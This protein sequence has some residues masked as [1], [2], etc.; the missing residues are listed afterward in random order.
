MQ[1][2][3]LPISSLV[4]YARNA[5]THSDAQVAQIAGSIR[6]FG[7]TNP[8]LIDASGGIIAGHGRVMAARALGMAD[9]P[10]IRLSHLTDVQRRA[11]VLADNRIAMNSGWDLDM[12]ALEFT[13]LQ[14]DGVEIPALG[15]DDAEIATILADPLPVDIDDLPA[16]L[17]HSVS[18]VGDVWIMGNHRLVCGDSM[19]DSVVSAALGGDSA[20]LTILDPPY[21][22][23]D[24]VWDAWI[25]DPCIVF[26]QARHLRRVPDALWRF[27][28]VIVKRYRHRSATVQI[29]HRHAFVAQCGTVKRLPCTTET[30]PSVIEQEIDRE[31]DHA[32]PVSLLVEHMTKWT[33]EWRRCID[34]FAGSCSSIIAAESCGRAC[35]AIELDPVYVDIGV[36]RWQELTGHDAILESSGR[37]FADTEAERTP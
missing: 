31:H 18:R 21:E 10:C 14:I 4:P 11:Y 22:M 13:E 28:R 17:P 23:P 33:P 12:L 32:K 35:S 16:P 15:F 25:S 8:V 20:S 37:T 1:I 7:F 2:E 26:G 24:K 5:R 36:R 30:F 3:Q 29:D 27:E 6:E 34:P 19:T 9:V